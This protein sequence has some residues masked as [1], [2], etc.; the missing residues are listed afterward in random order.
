M[1]RL[2]SRKATAWHSRGRGARR[3]QL[4]EFS[5]TLTTLTQGNNIRVKNYVISN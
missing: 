1:N 4:K 2:P 3:V 5:L